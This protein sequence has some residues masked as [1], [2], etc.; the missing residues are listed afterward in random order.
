VGAV[1]GDEWR[2]D[3][4]ELLW[5]LWDEGRSTAAIGVALKRSKNSVVGKAHRLGLP[6]RPS[7]I[8]P[9]RLDVKPKPAPRR[10]LPS[11]AVAVPVLR[12]VAPV[13]VKPPEPVRLDVPAP[14]P[15]RVMPS[16]G[17]GCQFVTDDTRHHQRFC[18][19]PRTGGSSYCPRHHAVCHM[20][21]PAT[22]I[23]WRFKF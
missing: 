23:P 14:P 11:L 8:R 19:A 4:L 16:A 17:G 12:V 15:M 1:I 18:E 22:G 6:A 3:E 21:A 2:D 20:T 9:K 7:P 13:V 5:V 10:T